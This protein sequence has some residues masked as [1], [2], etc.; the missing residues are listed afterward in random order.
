MH[1]V[2]NKTKCFS[3]EFAELKFIDEFHEADQNLLLGMEE[4]IVMAIKASKLKSGE[5]YPYV[6]VR[7]E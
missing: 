6:K 1:Y 2:F 7:E 4:S 3:K 5:N